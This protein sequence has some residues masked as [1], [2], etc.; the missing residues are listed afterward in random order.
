MNQSGGFTRSRLAV[1]LELVHQFVRE[2]VLEAS[3]IT[4]E[5]KNQA[6]AA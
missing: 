6:V 1:V 2:N 4:S 3:E 5:G